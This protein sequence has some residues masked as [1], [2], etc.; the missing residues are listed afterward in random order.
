MRRRLQIHPPNPGRSPIIGYT[1]V[2]VARQR[3]DGIHFRQVT[4]DGERLGSKESL[5]DATPRSG[6][7]KG[8]SNEIRWYH[9]TCCVPR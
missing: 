1:E 3:D 7:S 6:P 9:D 2:I 5:G 4:I 8:N